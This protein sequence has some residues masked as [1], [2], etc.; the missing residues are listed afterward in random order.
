MPRT[1]R[2]TNPALRPGGSRVLAHAPPRR[3]PSFSLVEML[4]ALT[5]LAILVAAH[6]TVLIHAMFS[7]LCSTNRFESLQTVRAAL[8]MI[9][10]DLRSA[11]DGVDAGSGA[12]PRARVPRTRRRDGRGDL[13]AVCGLPAR[14]GRHAEPVGAAEDQRARHALLAR[15]EYGRGRHRRGHVVTA[16]RRDRAR[17]I[18]A[19]QR[20]A[21]PSRPSGRAAGAGRG[22]DG[23]RDGA[24]RGELAGLQHANRSADAL[25]LSFKRDS[26]TG[27]ILRYDDTLSPPL[28]TATGMAVVEITSTGP[29]GTARAQ[30]R[31]DLSSS[32]CT[33]RS[34]G[35]CRREVA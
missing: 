12:G 19:C 8:D 34:P 14:H 21:D 3:A 4:V 27:A 7:W 10:R 32:R 30:V 13:R 33:R 23:V 20:C 5:V 2:A 1:G 29:T 22:L 25:T 31:T 26:A 15:Y 35:R 28:N 6:S 11:A 24:I 17:R 16:Q 9:A 18:G